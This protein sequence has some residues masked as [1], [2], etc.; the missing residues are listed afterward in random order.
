MTDKPSEWALREAEELIGGDG[1]RYFISQEEIEAVAAALD[2][3]RRDE[4]EKAVQRLLTFTYPPGHEFTRE[5]AAAA[6]SAVVDVPP[7]MPVECDAVIAERDRLRQALVEARDAL[8][9]TRNVLAMTKFEPDAG[10]PHP[11]PDYAYDR[12]IQ[13]SYDALTRIREALGDG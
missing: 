11:M 13:Q 2:A 5:L 10:E 4:R 6:I 1:D 7:R 8:E 3:A 12:A 9:I